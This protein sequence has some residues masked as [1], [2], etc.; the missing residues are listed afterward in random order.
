MDIPHAIH[1]SVLHAP[2]QSALRHDVDCYGA[3]CRHRRRPAFQ[4]KASDKTGR[5]G[6]R[7][8]A[9]AVGVP[10]VLPEQD[11]DIAR[12]F[13]CLSDDRQAEGEED[14]RAPA[15]ACFPGCTDFGIFRYPASDTFGFRLMLLVL[16][17]NKIK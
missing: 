3:D 16:V 11:M 8:L 12:H 10:A 14:N 7:S 5:P 15:Q 4:E 2:R 13:E 17:Q 6:Y 1:S 9:Q